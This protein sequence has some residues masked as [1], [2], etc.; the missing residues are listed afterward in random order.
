MKQFE[1]GGGFQSLV[2]GPVE[3]G[4]IFRTAAGGGAL[5]VSGLLRRNRMQPAHEQNQ[6]RSQPFAA[7]RNEIM[8]D[9]VDQ[10]NIGFENR[11]EFSFKRLQIF[12][13]RFDDVFQPHSALIEFIGSRLNTLEL[14]L[15]LKQKRGKPTPKLP[16]EKAL[17]LQCL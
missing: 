12:F 8:Y 15:S 1:N 11:L 13:D 4:R 17:P 14:L 2:L 16:A 6:H 5:I 3:G 10:K 7:V 9:F